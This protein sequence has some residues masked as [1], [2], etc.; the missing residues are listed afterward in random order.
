MKTD[1]TTFRKHV[2]RYLRSEGVGFIMAAAAAS[3]LSRALTFA[4]ITD[5]PDDAEIKLVVDHRGTGVRVVHGGTVLGEVAYNEYKLVSTDPTS[6]QRQIMDEQEAIL[7][8]IYAVDE[9]SPE[10]TSFIADA[11]RRYDALVEE[12]ISENRYADCQFIDYQKAV[13]FGELYKSDYGVRPAS[14]Y[15]GYD[16]VYDFIATRSCPC[17]DET[18]AAETAALVAAACTEQLPAELRA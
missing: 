5:I 6:R 14:G 8:M 17:T 16:E 12:S 15:R 1:T 7:Q 2:R 3:F 13:I 9:D 18:D 4:S 11:N 10:A